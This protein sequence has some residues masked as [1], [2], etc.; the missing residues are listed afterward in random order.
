MACCEGCA[1]GAGCGGGCKGC[2][3]GGG[4]SKHGH[5]GKH[6]H[7]HGAKRGHGGK[8][9]GGCSGCGGRGDDFWVPPCNGCYYGYYGDGCNPGCSGLGG[10]C[11]PINDCGGG[12]PMPLFAPLAPLASFAPLTSSVFGPRSSAMKMR[13]RDN[14]KR[15]YARGW[16][17]GQRAAQPYTGQVRAATLPTFV[18]AHAQGGLNLRSRPGATQP[19]GGLQNGTHVVVMMQGV[20][21]AACPA[22]EWWLVTVP[23]TGQRG[24]VLAVGPMGEANL[25]PE[26]A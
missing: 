16:A 10:P 4:G 22:C 15:A 7:G 26:L 3:G 25:Q 19:L 12:Y 2:S 11:G 1:K 20:R 5:G 21:D 9:H 13:D 8:H 17:R 23:T 18:V 14:N 6:G 24:Y